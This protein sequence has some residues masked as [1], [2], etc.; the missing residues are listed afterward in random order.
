[1]EAGHW[2]YNPDNWNGVAGFARYLPW[3]SVRVEVAEGSG[4]LP[5]QRILAYLFDP[6]AALWRTGLEAR[7]RAAAPTAL[8]FVVTNRGNTTDFTF[9]ISLAG[10]AVGTT[11]DGHLYGPNA[12]DVQLAPLVATLN[13]TTGLAEVVDRVPP[14]SIHFYV[15]RV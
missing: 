7:A 6:A 10:V 9:H 4:L 13:S 1:M 12:T 2:V 8:A 14:Y 5:D 11:F 3:D 15:Q